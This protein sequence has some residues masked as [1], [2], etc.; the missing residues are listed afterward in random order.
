MDR[1]ELRLRH[2]VQSLRNNVC[3]SERLLELKLVE[4]LIEVFQDDKEGLLQALRLASIKPKQEPNEPVIAIHPVRS[5][6]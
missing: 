4:K 2:A 1:R 3:D 5:K 6:L